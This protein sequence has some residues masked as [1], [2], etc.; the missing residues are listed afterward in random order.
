MH[1]NI[2]HLAT[3]MVIYNLYGTENY[4][5]TSLPLWGKVGNASRVTGSHILIHIYGI[6]RQG[7]NDRRWCDRTHSLQKHSHG[8]NETNSVGRLVANQPRGDDIDPNMPLVLAASHSV[9]QFVLPSD[10]A[11]ITMIYLYPLWS[12]TIYGLSSNCLR[13]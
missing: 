6:R 9:A 1:F 5:F 2:P 7:M 11:D 8:W 10:R 4:I 3:K 12:S 13:M